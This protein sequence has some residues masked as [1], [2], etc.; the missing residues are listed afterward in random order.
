MRRHAKYYYLLLGVIVALSMLFLLSPREPTYVQK[1][2][3]QWLKELD[4][5]KGQPNY[6]AAQAIRQIGTNALPVLL[7]IQRSQDSHA[8]QTLMALLDKQ[9]WTD[10]RLQAASEKRARASAAFK[11]LGPIAKP[12]I[13][14]LIELLGSV[15]PEQGGGLAI[16]AA[17]AL[18]WIG[19]DTALPLA[20]ALSHTNR[21]VRY[22][23]AVA[24]E[25]LGRDSRL[26]VPALI[27]SLNDPDPEVRLC[28]VR[29]VGKVPQEPELVVPALMT[30]FSTADIEE[31]KALIVALGNFGSGAKAAIPVLLK[32]IQTESN[33][34]VGAA[35]S[36]LKNID[37][38]AIRPIGE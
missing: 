22:Y 34:T 23:A 30:R 6:P 27:K 36:A 13:P 5:W 38:D 32:I 14:S 28:V 15:N 21:W 4:N 25:K 9:S 29:T 33:A 26:A 11:V 24:L 17:W 35:L 37:P 16:D 1:K 10:V 12:A 18:A 19:S 3:S 7:K 2:L 31:R 20:N 8:K